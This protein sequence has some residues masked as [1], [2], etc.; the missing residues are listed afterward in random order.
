MHVIYNTHHAAVS[1]F[2][3]HPQYIILQQGSRT[4]ISLISFLCPTRFIKTLPSAD[5]QIYT[6]YCKIYLFFSNKHLPHTADAMPRH[7]DHATKSHYAPPNPTKQ[8]RHDVRQQKSQPLPRTQQTRPQKKTPPSTEHLTQ[9]AT[10]ALLSGLT[11]AIRSRHK[12]DQSERVLRAA[13][14]AA[15]VNVFMSKEDSGASLKSVVGG[16]LIN[17][18][19]GPHVKH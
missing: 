5:G 7:H 17:R 8:R 14:G 3:T 12:P 9:L 16:M 11:E 15:A 10:A 19:V 18:L 2:Q 6:K 13:V 4:A 1:G